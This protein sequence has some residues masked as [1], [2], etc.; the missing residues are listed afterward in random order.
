MAAAEEQAQAAPNT[1][2][3]TTPLMNA[4]VQGNVEEVKELLSEGADVNA[5]YS[6][7]GASAL[8]IA[9]R[10]GNRELINILASFPGADI[11]IKNKDGVSALM[12]AEQ[13]GL[14]DVV[15]LLK[16]KGAV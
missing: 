4:V 12:L 10:G 5:V 14:M 15:E 7:T 11:N 16:Q 1:F 3:Q 13:S 9:V 8:W 2:F 6:G